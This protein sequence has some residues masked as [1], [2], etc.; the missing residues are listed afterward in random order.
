M[1]VKNIMKLVIFASYVAFFMI[2]E[3]MMGCSGSGIMGISFLVYSVIFLILM[4]SVKETLARMVSVRRHR[5]F[6]DNAKRIFGYCICYCTGISVAVITLSYFLSGKISE[7]IC[8]DRSIEMVL[9]ILGVFFALEAF[10]ATIRGYYIGCNGSV[11]LTIG[12]I[13]KCI[14][15][16]V[17]T[18]LGIKYLGELGSK[19]AGLHKN[20]FLT[21]VY[22]SMGAAIALCF[23]DILMLVVLLSGLKGA[24]RNDSFS[25]NEVRSRDGFKSFSRAF[26]PLTLGWLQ[27]NIMPTLTIFVLICFYCRFCLKQS[28]DFKMMY[29]E[30][31]T[32]FTPALV[33][34]FVALMCFKKYAGIYRKKLR[35]DFKKDDKKSLVSDF[36]ILLKNSLVVAAPIALS[37]MTL[38][39]K[40]SVAFFGCEGENAGKMLI[41]V[42][43]LLVFAC[44]DYLFA[45][46]L[47]CIGHD[48]MCFG[49]RCVGFVLSL[50]MALSLNSK[51]FKISFVVTALLIGYGACAVLGGAFVVRFMQVRTNDII[52][53]LVKVVIAATVL[54]VVD[55]IFVKLIPANAI[56]VIF[57]LLVGY[58]LY[59]LVLI[60]LK[61]FSA[62]DIEGLKGSLLYYPLT[63]LGNVLRIR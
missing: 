10:G 27:K 9:I 63:L 54:A 32:L 15:M 3:R 51:D 5:G 18:P 53:R 59:I 25:F 34:F 42:G 30:A 21:V 6:V 41:Q 57:A 50:I 49:C 31:G 22:G 35:V 38:S 46:V 55:L 17:L 52:A 23:S 24:L 37:V 58:I 11:F 43:I 56:V 44:F 8:G 1:N 33:V 14:S 45:E 62:K 48:L 39:G 47:E 26:V 12:E 20:E 28:I 19:A 29:S 60:A 7:K 2:C 13:V 4:G 40:I 16:L 36:N 61:T